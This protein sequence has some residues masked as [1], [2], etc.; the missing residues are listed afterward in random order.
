M[1]RIEILK[2]IPVKIWL[3]RNIIVPPSPHPTPSPPL[4]LPVFVSVLGW[5]SKSNVEA[6]PSIFL[7]RFEHRARVWRISFAV[8][9]NKMNLNIA[10]WISGESS[11]ERGK[12]TL[13]NGINYV[14]FSFKVNQMLKGP[15]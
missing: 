9:F 11:R 3:P 15:F 13:L 8:L 5:K 7:S 2:D 6:N 12:S 1:Q 4:L 10:L 14:F